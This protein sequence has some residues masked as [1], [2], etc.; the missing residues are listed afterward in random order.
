MHIETTTKLQI[1]EYQEIFLLCIRVMAVACMWVCSY[2][3]KP[4]LWL[5]C[6]FSLHD[7]FNCLVSCSSLPN[8]NNG[9]ITCLLGDDGAPSYG[10]TCS[11]TCNTGYELTGSDTRTC[12]SDGSWSGSDVICSKG[13]LNNY[14][15]ASKMCT[16]NNTYMYV[17]YHFILLN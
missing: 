10:D 6:S 5:L 15:V 4:L 11:F 16:Y 14:M 7:L 2:V 17:M 13:K 3:N 1:Y 9:I 12:Q 8:P